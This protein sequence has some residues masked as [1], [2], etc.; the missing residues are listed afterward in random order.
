MSITQQRERFEALAQRA[1]AD[2]DN[3]PEAY[4]RKLKW[5]FLFGYGYL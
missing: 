5:L 3:N 4:K 2:F 1:E